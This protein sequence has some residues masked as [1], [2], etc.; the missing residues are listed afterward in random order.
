M[1]GNL[2]FNV[3]CKLVV[4]S[5]V[6]GAVNESFTLHKDKLVDVTFVMLNFDV[7][8]FFPIYVMYFWNG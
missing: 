7:N 3:Q 1:L 4:S 8:E 5:S 6:V 2:I